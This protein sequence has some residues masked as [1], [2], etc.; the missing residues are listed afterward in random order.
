MKLRR[1]T[2]VALFLLICTAAASAQKGSCAAK[3]PPEFRTFR[4]G[5]TTLEVRSRLEDTTTFDQ[6]FSGPANGPGAQGVRITAADLKESLAENLDS[7][8]LAFIDGRLASI[9][10]T[11]LSAEQWDG[12][13][14]FIKR[15]SADLGLPEGAG[16]STGTRGNEKYRVECQTFAVVIAYSFGVSPNV[17][18]NDIAAQKIADERLSNEGEIKTINLTPQGRPPGRKP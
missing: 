1:L 8:D 18:I 14:D 10:I 17:T 11:Y 4:L 16:T 15:E 2:V 13:Q 7:L 9:K 6:A 12:A 5:M 3:A